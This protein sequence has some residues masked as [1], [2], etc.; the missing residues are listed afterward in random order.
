VVEAALAMTVHCREPIG[1]DD[2]E[3]R[4]RARDLVL[5][6][7]QEVQTWLDVINVDEYLIARKALGQGVLESACRVPVVVPPAGN[8]NPSCHGPLQ[9]AIGRV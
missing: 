8:E 4:V 1:T 6:H 9:I 5:D 2:D 3:H 7:L